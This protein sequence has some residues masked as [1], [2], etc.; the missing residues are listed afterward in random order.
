MVR[1]LVVALLVSATCA[2]PAQADLCSQVRGLLQARSTKFAQFQGARV[3]K[4]ADIFVANATL[5]GA[6][7]CQVSTS[8]ENSFYKCHWDTSRAA[9]SR[10]YAR[11]QKSLSACLGTAVKGQHRTE[12]GDDIW[13]TTYYFAPDSN[14]MVHLMAQRGKTVNAVDLAVFSDPPSY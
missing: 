8:A 7:R 4:D 12:R 11:M 1:H 5:P 3:F 10:Q 13:Q 14:G 9:V 6:T 2:G